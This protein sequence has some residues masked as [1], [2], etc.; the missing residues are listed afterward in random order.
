MQTHGETLSVQGNNRGSI[1]G[2]GFIPSL[3]EGGWGWRGTALAQS[4][5]LGAGMLIV[6]GQAGA[7]M[8]VDDRGT[9]PKP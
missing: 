6:R 7:R 5:M 3:L 9:P 4:V 1:A 8:F 2:L